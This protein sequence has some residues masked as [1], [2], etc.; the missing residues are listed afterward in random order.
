L[1]LAV[2]GQIGD[3]YSAVLPIAE[4]RISATIANEKVC[5]YRLRGADG[6]SKD[7]FQKIGH[8]FPDMHIPILAFFVFSTGSSSAFRLVRAG[9]PFVTSPEAVTAS[10][11]TWL[12]WL[13][14]ASTELT[15]ADATASDGETT[16][17][18]A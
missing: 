14:L 4:T 15:G 8:S 10:E 17:R 11:I 3:E 9:A 5:T 13:S 7:A 12:T 16:L 1:L 6:G 2:C 18:D